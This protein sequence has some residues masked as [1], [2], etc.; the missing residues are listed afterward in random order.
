MSEAKPPYVRFEVSDELVEKTLEAFE[1]ARETGKI[2]KGT[3]EVTK[4][5]ER[6]RAKLVAIAMDVSPPEIVMH[7]PVLCEEK[8]VPY[9]Y[10]YS[11]KSLGEAVGIAVSAASA[12]IEEEGDAKAMVKE[13]VGEV[14]KLKGKPVEEKEEP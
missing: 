6:G 12:C 1:I 2:R 4:S 7:L 14:Q 11:K 13:I 5:V 3:N 8:N 10:V 9:T